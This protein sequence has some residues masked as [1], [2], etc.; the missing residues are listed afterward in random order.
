MVPPQVA[1]GL[2]ALRVAA[3]RGADHPC[4]ARRV[5]GPHA[6]ITVCRPEVE[7][8]GAARLRVHGSPTRRRTRLHVLPSTVAL[9]RVNSTTEDDADGVACALRR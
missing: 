6:P 4:S 1:L 7:V 9:V 5:V 3:W 2:G 8:V